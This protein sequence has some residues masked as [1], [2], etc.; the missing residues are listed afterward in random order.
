MQKTIS[1]VIPDRMKIKKVGKLL[2]KI[3]NLFDNIKEEG[4]IS[5]IEKD[6]FLA[7]IKE[8]YEASIDTDAAEEVKSLVKEVSQTPVVETPVVQEA[9]VTLSDIP[10]ENI[11][12]EVEVAEVPPAPVAPEPVLDERELRRLRRQEEKEKR[13]QE[14]QQRL[15]QRKQRRAAPTVS[16]EPVQSTADDNGSGSHGIENHANGANGA[17]PNQ[18]VYNEPVQQQVQQTLTEESPIPQSKSVSFSEE[19]LAIFEKQEIAEVS[20]RLSMTPIADLTKAMGINEKIFTVRELFN[21]DQDHFMSTMSHLNSCN[22][23][24]EARDY[25]LYGV[26]TDNAWDDPNKSKKAINFIKLVQRRYRK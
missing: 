15:E 23:F 9:P 26:A 8:I 17:V 4:T 1:H 25:L 12:Q 3:N 6:L 11:N 2:K 14:R 10:T 19:M 7:Y 18:E 22:D 24:E 21:K 13:E 20:D 5:S 16:R